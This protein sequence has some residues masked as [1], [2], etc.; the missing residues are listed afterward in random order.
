MEWG[1]LLEKYLLLS[2]FSIHLIFKG[3]PVYLIDGEIM[4]PQLLID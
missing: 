3:I 1:D 2:S 4:I